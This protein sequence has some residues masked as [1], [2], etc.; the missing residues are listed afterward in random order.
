MLIDRW[1]QISHSGV[2]IDQCESFGRIVRN[3]S[4]AAGEADLIDE[5][6]LGLGQPTGVRFDLNRREDRQSSSDMVF[7]NLYGREPDQIGRTWT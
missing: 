1:R 3:T 2:P 4:D 7:A 6:L 5:I